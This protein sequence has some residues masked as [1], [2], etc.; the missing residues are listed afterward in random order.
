MVHSL[1]FRLFFLQYSWVAESA[2]LRILHAFV[3]YVS[4]ALRALLPHVPHVPHVPRVLCAFQKLHLRK[5]SYS[6]TSTIVLVWNL[7]FIIY[8]HI[9]YIYVYHIYIYIYVFYI[10]NLLLGDSLKCLWQRF[11]PRAVN[12]WA[13]MY[14]DDITRR[15]PVYMIIY[16]VKTLF[17]NASWR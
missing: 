14:F 1:H 10:D 8:I 15:S 4:R 9:Y 17:C 3:H 12:I 13:V 6:T 7:F 5:S 2:K 11:D 16:A